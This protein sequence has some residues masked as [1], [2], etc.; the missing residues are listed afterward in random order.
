MLIYSKSY[1]KLKTNLRQN[2]AIIWRAQMRYLTIISVLET[3]R[4]P[5]LVKTQTAL[6][7]QKINKIWQKTISNMADGI[8]TPCNV[9]RSWL[10]S[11]GDCTLQC[12]MWLW[13]HDSEFTSS[14]LQCDRWLCDD[15][16]LNSPGGSTLQCGRC[17]LCDDMPWN[18]RKRPP[19]WTSGFDFDHITTVDISFCISL[20]NF[21]Q[22]GPPS[23]EK[24]GVMSIF[25][26]ADLPHLGF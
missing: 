16:P 11:P 14:T 6:K 13:N 23:A 19:H 1:D 25:N 8:I 18:S 12:G 15:M 2:L 9:A 24:N 22:I 26:M 17:T 10:I 20:R 4:K 21:I 5:P 3:M 7:N